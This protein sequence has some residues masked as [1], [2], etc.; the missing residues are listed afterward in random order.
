MSSIENVRFPELFGD[1]ERQVQADLILHHW[2]LTDT[3][4]IQF[5]PLVFLLS[6]FCD[7]KSIVTS[8]PSHSL[9]HSDRIIPHVLF[10]FCYCSLLLEGLS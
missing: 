7:P 3:R 5:S 8:F 4:L 1:E 6:L 10:A 2:P 9:I